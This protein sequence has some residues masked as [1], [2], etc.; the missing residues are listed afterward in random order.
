MTLHLVVQAYEEI[1]HLVAQLVGLV[2]ND[3]RGI[4]TVQRLHYGVHL[5]GHATAHVFAQG[6]SSLFMNVGRFQYSLH[7][8]WYT[9]RVVLV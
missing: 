7:L 6:R 5:V 8:K 2:Q 1:K 4:G 9:L 3:K